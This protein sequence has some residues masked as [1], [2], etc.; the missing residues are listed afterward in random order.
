MITTG[1]MTIR[2]DSNDAVNTFVNSPLNLWIATI[3]AKD[4]Y[5]I[6]VKMLDSN[7]ISMALSTISC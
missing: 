1:S 2:T 6:T 4:A 3:M 5:H 7:I